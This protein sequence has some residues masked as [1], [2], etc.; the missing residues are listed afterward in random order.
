VRL[1]ELLAGHLKE[2]KVL[3]SRHVGKLFQNF[4]RPV[5]RPRLERVTPGPSFV[6]RCHPATP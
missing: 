6:S 3:A 5:I 4:H 1:A 2:M